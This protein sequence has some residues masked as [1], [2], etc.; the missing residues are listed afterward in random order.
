MLIDLIRNHRSVDAIEVPPVGW[1]AH[2]E[3]V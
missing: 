3:G 1:K 2:E